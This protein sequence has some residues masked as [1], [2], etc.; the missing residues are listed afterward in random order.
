[1]SNGKISGKATPARSGCASD[2]ANGHIA[3]N[4]D[5]GEPARSAGC[6]SDDAKPV[7]APSASTRTGT[8]QEAVLALLRDPKGATIAAIMAATGWQQHSVRGFLSAVVR[9]KLGLAR[10]AEKIGAERVYRVTVAQPSKSKRRT[11][12]R[13]AA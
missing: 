10:I 8:K 7:G 5:S 4:A 9:K 11:S 12:A 1:M 13:S 6:A 2:Q 3:S